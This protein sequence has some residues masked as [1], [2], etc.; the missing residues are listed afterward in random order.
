MWVF[1][2]LNFIL[3][4]A[5]SPVGIGVV[6]FAFLASCLVRL[7][8]RSNWSRILYRVISCGILFYLGCWTA[9]LGNPEWG[10]RPNDIFFAAMFAL[11]FGLPFSVGWLIAWPVA[12]CLQIA[13]R[14]RPSNRSWDHVRL[15]ALSRSAQ[16]FHKH[17]LSVME[18]T[19]RGWGPSVC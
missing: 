13:L 9:V 17:P 6:F 12:V 18:R 4:F 11:F 8:S 19:K 1:T 14:E 2:G 16:S 7:L 15:L 5:G 10:G 3:V